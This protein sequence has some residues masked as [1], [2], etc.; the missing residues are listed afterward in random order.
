[1]INTPNNS[2]LELSREVFSLGLNLLRMNRIPS[3]S[4]HFR[5]ALSFDPLFTDAALHLAHCLHLEKKFLSALEIYDQLISDSC[6]NAHILNNRGNT[7][8]EM[9]RYQE[10]ASSFE[11]A[12]EL[13]PHLHDARVTLATCYQAMG[14]IKEAMA[15]C[16]AV[17]AAA[18]DH[19]EAHWNRA[20]LL[21]L[22]GDY[23]AG[24]KE[25]EWRW[26]K[27]NFSS[28]RRDFPQ[29]RWNEEPVQGKTILIHAEQGFG[30]TIQLS[31]Y[32]P[33]LADT[34]AKV[35][36]ECHPPL[37]SLLKNLDSRI[38]VMEQDHPLPDFDLHLPL[39]SLPMIFGTTLETIP[40]NIPYL[41]SSAETS[42]IS[43]L[44]DTLKFKIGICWAGKSY[45][46]PSRS[47]SA[48]L[49]APLGELDGIAWY[50]LQMQTNEKLPFPATNL[51]PLIKDFNDTAMFMEHL[52]LIITIDTAVAHLAGAMGKAAWIMLAY[53]PD[54]RW[55]LERKD[56]PWYPSARLFRQKDLGGWHEIL[57]EIKSALFY[58]CTYETV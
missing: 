52:D 36:F 53:A 19:A 41:K 42:N 2:T 12:L 11:Q 57:E 33:M 24:W 22:R 56:S 38:V 6:E 9:C 50:S 44:F 25:Y 3:A 26:Q 30:D 18:P 47:C 58:C 48:E 7:L 32:L 43:H 17:L 46:D 15:A 37:V 55:M 34:G 8:L 39:L 27:R 10:A 4:F 45:P 40:S 16:N 35:I 14:R 1:M 23:Q 54:W 28:P 5:K 13:A 49:L 29:P 51:A 20:L 31:R 21:L